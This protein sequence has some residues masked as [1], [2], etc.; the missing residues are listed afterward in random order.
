[1]FEND[2]HMVLTFTDLVKGEG[3]QSNQMVIIHEGHSAIFDPGGDLTYMPL[4]MAITKYVKVKDIEYVIA[5]HQD[6]D[7]V[8]SLDKWLIYSEAKIVISQLWERFIP[9]LIPGYMKEKA[10]GRMIAIPDQG[11]NIP[12]GHSIIKAIP[13]HFLHS[14]G[15]FHFY[16]PISKILFSGDV[17]ASLVDSEP[18]QP[19][20]D[21][22]KHVKKMLGFHQRYMVS[23]KVCRLWVN[24][25]REMDVEMIVPQHGRPFKGNEM[26]DRFLDWFE[27]LECGIDR[28]NQQYYT[29]P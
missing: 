6:P 8:S 29:A 1:M 23:N 17:G 22:E 7:I 10:E 11:M 4:S 2:D 13:A 12:M 26:V 19:V 25:I 5:T 14:V 18:E 20:R 24:M 28:V 9:H 3:I 16:D 21:F 15:N 27:T